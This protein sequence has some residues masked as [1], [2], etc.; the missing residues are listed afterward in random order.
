M[1][2]LVANIHSFY[3]P[4]VSLVSGA[5]EICSAD[6]YRNAPLFNLRQSSLQ[7]VS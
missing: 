7:I 3:V 2:A 1:G 5:A 6:L 4:S